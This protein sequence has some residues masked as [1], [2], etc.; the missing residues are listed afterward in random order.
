MSNY[1]VQIAVGLPR[2]DGET[3]AEYL[4]RTSKKPKGVWDERRKTYILPSGT[5][6]QGRRPM[7]QPFSDSAG[8]EQ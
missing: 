7:F 1:N 8:Q 4:N 5:V 6:K 2:H 3:L